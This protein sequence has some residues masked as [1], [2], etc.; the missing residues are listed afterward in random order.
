VVVVVVVVTVVV[1]VVVVVVVGMH[2][3]GSASWAPVH[4]SPTGQLPRQMG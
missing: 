3:Q 2:V 4:V 1:V